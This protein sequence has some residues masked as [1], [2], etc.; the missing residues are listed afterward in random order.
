MESRPALA[1]STVRP[2]KHDCRPPVD[3]TASDRYREPG[4]FER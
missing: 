3:R 2:R 1:A 4:L